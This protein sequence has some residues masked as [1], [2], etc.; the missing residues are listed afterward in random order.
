[1]I[2]LIGISLAFATVAFF[3]TE[4]VRSY[5]GL[6]TIFRDIDKGA[7]FTLGML[8]AGIFVQTV[9]G[10]IVGLVMIVVS[11]SQHKRR[12]AIIASAVTTVVVTSLM[13]C[14]AHGRR[15][16]DTHLSVGSTSLRRSL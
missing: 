13:L 4:S 15:V 5:W 8:V 1:M 10:L 2:R 7:W 11:P 3:L 16:D 6:T 9:F 14:G 12:R